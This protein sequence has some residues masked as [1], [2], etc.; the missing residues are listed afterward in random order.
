VPVTPVRTAA[1]KKAAPP[2][3][4]IHD[5]ETG[6]S[7]NVCYCSVHGMQ[8][9]KKNGAH[10][11]KECPDRTTN[12]NWKEGATLMERLGGSDKITCGRQA[13]PSK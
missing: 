10:A 4:T 7:Y 6:R 8:N 13:A 12:T 11:N 5:A 9:A 3:T 2:S 1:T